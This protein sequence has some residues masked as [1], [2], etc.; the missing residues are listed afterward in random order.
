MMEDRALEIAKL[1]KEEKIGS[2]LIC[3]TYKAKN[4]NAL[5]QELKDSTTNADDVKYF[6]N[7]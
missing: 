5:G 2:R 1:D 6:K 4:I 3:H 7:T